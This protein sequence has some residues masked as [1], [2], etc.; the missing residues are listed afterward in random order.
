MSLFEYSYTKALYYSKSKFAKY[1][2][3]FL[4]LLESFVLPLPIQDLLLMIMSLSDRKKAYYYALIC[5]LGSVSGAII[6]YLLGLFASEWIINI[7]NKVGYADYFN[8][9]KIWFETYGY[10]ILILAAFTPIPFKLFTIISGIMYMP[11][12][13]FILIAFIARGMRYSLISF[14]I[15]V[16][17]EDVDKWLRK[18]INQIGYLI[19]IVILF[20]LIYNSL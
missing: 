15:R 12:T 3:F 11:I 13:I 14:I 4:S 5:S 8:E 16:F 18:Y 6:G 7:I 1:W 10:F 17:G 2:L 19:I 20:Y 9:A